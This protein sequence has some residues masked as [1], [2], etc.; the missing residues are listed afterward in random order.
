MVGDEFNE[1]VI[2]LP[3]AVT[4]P[5]RKLDLPMSDFVHAL[6]VARRALGDTVWVFP[7]NSQSGHIEEPKFFLARVRDV[8][9]IEISAHDLRRSFVTTAEACDLSAYALKGLV[10]HSLGNDVTS[11][12]I[13]MNAERL[14][15]PAQRVTDRLKD[16][17]GIA[18]VS[19]ENVK[20][21]RS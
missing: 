2:R 11:G 8:T 3:A 20:R 9:G 16:L 10:N 4:K 15:E 5:G 17:C 21:L 19:G 12:Y 6:L 13:Q 7:A 14:R 1:R 18:P